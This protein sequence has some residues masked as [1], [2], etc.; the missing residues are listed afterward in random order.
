MIDIDKEDILE[1]FRSK[2]KKHSKI[3]RGRKEDT[4]SRYFS[5]LKSFLEFYCND[6]SELKTKDVTDYKKYLK[7]KGYSDGTINVKLTALAQ[8]IKYLNNKKGYK[9]YNVRIEKIEIPR[10]EYLEKVIT[11]EQFAAIQEKC[12]RSRDIRS[13]AIFNTLYYTGCRVSELERIPIGAVKSEKC[14]IKGKG[15]INRYLYLSN[16]LL[17]R[18]LN[19]Y[20][21]S[22]EN[23]SASLF[24][25]INGSLSVRRIQQLWS[26]YCKECSIQ[27]LGIHTLRHLYALEYIK[28][29]GNENAIYEL[30]KRLGHKNLDTTFIYLV[31]KE[32]SIKDQINKIK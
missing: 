21:K 9:I 7:E 19:A 3:R 15:D 22:R 6:I 1:Y 28:A 16:N 24:T 14:N 30:Q 20:L 17:Q 23:T 29:N 2:K 13:L 5:N 26:F 4:L 10:K 11:R 25:G 8:F 12:R 18:T 31:N 27:G 32:D